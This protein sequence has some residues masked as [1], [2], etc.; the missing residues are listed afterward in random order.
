MVTS[1][2]DRFEL[3]KMPMNKTKKIL[4]ITEDFPS[5]LNGASVRTRSTL[6]SILSL[7][8]SVEVCCFHFIDFSIHDLKHK[9]LKIHTIATKKRKKLS[10]SFLLYIFKLV[11]SQAPISIRRLYNVDLQHKI[12][13]L[14][15]KKFDIVVYDGY[16]TLQYLNRQFLGKS[17]FIDTEDFTQLYFRRCVEEQRIIQ[18]IFY[19]LEYLKSSVFEKNT[20]RFVDQ[21]WA[22]SPNT[23]KRLENM[24]KKDTF[25]MPTYI[26]KEKNIY[27][28]E[29]KKIVFTGT[30]NWRENVEGLR[31]FIDTH[32]GTVL[33]RNP[34][35]KL[36]VIG[37]GASFELQTFLKS[38]KNIIYKGYVE[39]LA[40]EY[41]KAVLAISPVLINA[42]I[43]VKILTYLSYGLPVVS[44]PTASWGLVNTD[45]VV[46]AENV[47]FA[48]KII[49]LLKKPKQRRLLSKQGYANIANNYSL[50][51]LS[52]FIKERFRE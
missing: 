3:R 41:S 28:G 35:T 42:G 14:L 2:L 10:I 13:Q 44:T 30:L 7:G 11:F 8:Y 15:Q 45:G 26:A 34:G 25:L 39:K 9:N 32:W 48:Q 36:I 43:K 24:S 12:D 29:G 22:I 33:E 4:F 17:I 19:F 40:T 18:K 16:S 27:S 50:K 21:I 5:G 38:Q 52:K 23:K 31:W 20:M 37:Q 1:N 46:I 49:E 51:G 6:K 47:F